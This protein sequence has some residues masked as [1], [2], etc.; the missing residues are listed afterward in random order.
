MWISQK[1]HIYLTQRPT[2]N[3]KHKYKHTN[4]NLSVVPF[5]VGLV[6]LRSTILTHSHVQ[7]YIHNRICNK[8]FRVCIQENEINEELR[9]TGYDI[10]VHARGCY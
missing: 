4:S 1:T 9:K 5:V 3:L 6:L 8:A 10:C 7:L 2:V